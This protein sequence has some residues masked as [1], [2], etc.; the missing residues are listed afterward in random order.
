[1]LAAVGPER[2]VFSLDLKAGVPWTAAPAWQG[3]TAQMIAD[4]VLALGVRR[5]IVLDLARVG[6][7]EGV[8]TEPLGSILQQS[9]P[10]TEFIAGGG[11][12]GLSDV[13]RLEAAGY[14]AVLVASA[15]HDGRIMPDE[16]ARLRT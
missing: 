1:M 9:W 6:M 5:L 16:V 4:H 14:D 7:G 8:A 10:D 12:R 13:A 3:W 11:V 15:L 2:L